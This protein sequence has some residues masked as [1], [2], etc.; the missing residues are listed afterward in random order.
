MTRILDVLAENTQG[1]DFIV[2]DLHG[3][4]QQLTLA[5]EEVGFNPLQDRLLSV[6]DLVDRGPDSE[7]CLQLL[8]QPWFFAVQGNHERFLLHAVA[9]DEAVMQT[10]LQN[11][12]RWSSLYS[13]DELEALLLLIEQK[14]PLA[15]EVSV[16]GKKLGIIHAE[17]PEDNWQNL[18]N[19]RGDITKEL[20]EVVT[21]RRQRIRNQLQ[22]SVANIDVVACGHTLVEKPLR[23]GNVHCLETGVC[24]PQ[25]GGYLTLIEARDLLLP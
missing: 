23:L 25:L 24:A 18:Q 20:L 2:G 22:L 13:Q 16:E 6:G 5:L 8:N 12:G 17:V 14:M 3:Y 21:T 15:L 1:R 11:G 4:Y 10:W 9:G 19:W 7:A